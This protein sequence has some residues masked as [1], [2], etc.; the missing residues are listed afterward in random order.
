MEL[1]QHKTF[2]NKTVAKQLKL[3][4]ICA[5]TLKKTLSCLNQISTITPLHALQQQLG[6]YLR[7]WFPQGEFAPMSEAELNTWLTDSEN[8]LRL[9]EYAKHFLKGMLVDDDPEMIKQISAVIRLVEIIKSLAQ[10]QA[11]LHEFEQDKLSSVISMCQTSL[12]DNG[13]KFATY[14]SLQ[15]F[16]VNRINQQ[17][18]AMPKNFLKQLLSILATAQDLGGSDVDKYNYLAQQLFSLCAKW[19]RISHNRAIPNFMIEFDQGYSTWQSENDIAI[20]G[21]TNQ[22]VLFGINL[23]SQEL[24]YFIPTDAKRVDQNQLAASRL[25]I[26][27]EFASESSKL[28]LHSY[29]FRYIHLLDSQELLST[30]NHYFLETSDEEVSPDRIRP[31]IERNQSW[32]LK[33][34]ITKLVEFIQ[35]YKSESKNILIQQLIIVMLE[36][37]HK[38]ETYDSIPLA[39]LEISEV[40]TNLATALTAIIQ[41]LEAEYNQEKFDYITVL[42]YELICLAIYKLEPEVFFGQQPLLSPTEEIISVLPYDYIDYSDIDLPEEKEVEFFLEESVT[43]DWLDELYASTIN[44][45][46]NFR[47][48]LNEL[49]D[50]VQTAK[51]KRSEDKL[52]II[53][54]VQSAIQ[55]ADTHGCKNKAKLHLLQQLVL[56]YKRIRQKRFGERA[57]WSRNSGGKFIFSWDVL[58]L[59]NQGLFGSTLGDGLV[60]ILVRAGITLENAASQ[61]DC[62]LPECNHNFS[63]QI[64]A[65]ITNPNKKF[66]NLLWEQNNKYEQRDQI[67]LHQERATLARLGEELDFVKL[68]SVRSF[69]VEVVC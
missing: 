9:P 49:M 13:L 44:P 61:A 35:E 7:T 68:G 40:K 48:L 33:L 2:I 8:L 26:Q 28:P 30:L 21:I 36:Q 19:S 23:A 38:D 11:E 34:V 69:G 45:F 54:A 56:I 18:P 63:T 6:E 3:D 67:D 37:F 57:T 52:A 27:H 58:S 24:C 46:L 47:N 60:D 15:Q 1:F 59:Q 62:H 17:H 66:L 42:A 55:H 43:Q 22:G 41:P 20:I 4:Q 25:L 12:Y 53:T 16:L 32:D 50:L 10:F 64:Q 5:N 51:S 14:R 31:W 29:A 65:I 39:D